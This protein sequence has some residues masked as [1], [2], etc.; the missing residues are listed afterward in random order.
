MSELFKVP[1]RNLFV[2]LSYADNMPEL[3]NSLNGVDE[4][5]ITYD[6]ICKQFLKEVE[7]VNRRGLV[8][9]YVSQTEPTNRL[10]GRMIM[11]ESIP[12]IIA[13]KPLVVCEKDEYT[14]NILLNQ[15]IKSTLRAITVNRYVKKD[16]KSRSFNHMEL[17]SEVNAPPLTKASFAKIHFG[18]HNMHYK[19]VLQI[20]RLLHEMTLLS[21]KNGNW[22][23]FS[24]ELDDRA[25]NSLFEKFLFNFYKLEQQDY[26]VKVEGMQWKLEGDKTYLPGMRTDVSLIHRKKP[27]KIIIDAKF[28]KDIFQVHHEKSS[29]RSNHMYQ[30]FTYLMHQPQE[31]DLRGILIYPLNGT[32]VNE[33]YKWNERMTVE[34]MSLDL[35]GTWQEIYQKLHCLVKQY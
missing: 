23:L 30:L 9:D 20:A 13:K 1:I 10:A 14:A 21:H 28:Y 3:V 32:G 35:D 29:F 17:M 19:R 2:L 6:F 15:L 34:I 12:Y 27:E 16:T 31:M 5:I 24:A 8:K 7:L 25:L 22:S 4:D 26:Q 18:R 11:E 33:K